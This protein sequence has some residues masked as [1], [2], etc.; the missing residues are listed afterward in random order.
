MYL[1]YLGSD[2]ASSASA[3]QQASDLSGYDRQFK[4][5]MDRTE[6]FTSRVEKLH[7][8]ATGLKK[9]FKQVPSKILVVLF[10]LFDY[11]RTHTYPLYLSNEMYHI[12]SCIYIFDALR[13]IKSYRQVGI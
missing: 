13:Y 9:G 2:Y 11:S 6:N 4:A 3:K 5:L 1:S 12:S 10:L 8:T 7:D